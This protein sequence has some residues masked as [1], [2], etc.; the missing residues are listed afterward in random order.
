MKCLD[1]EKLIRYA[2]H[3]SDEAA[4]SEVRAHL[5]KCLRCREIVEQYGRLDALLDEWKVAEPTP[6]FDARV[7]QAVEAQQA[8]RAAWGFGSLGW[9]R[10]LAVAA[11]GVLIVAGSVWIIRA[12]YRTSNSARVATRQVQPPMGPQASTSATKLLSANVAPPAG[13][14]PAHAASELGSSRAVAKDDQDALALEDYDLAANFDL[15]SE[16]PK[17]EQRVVN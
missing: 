5:G 11:L 6:G 4:A 2:Y 14:R 1:T 17:A 12:H 10:G 13:V 3:L 15:L 9:A 16:L 7:R 8:R